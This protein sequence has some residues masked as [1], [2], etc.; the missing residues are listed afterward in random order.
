MISDSS[1][2]TPVFIEVKPDWQK[3]VQVV[4][5]FR[6]TIAETR[7]EGRQR[8]RWRGSPRYSITYLSTALTIAEH[9]LRRAE[10]LGELK[11]PLVCPIWPDA[12]ALDSMLSTHVADLGE[13]LAKKRF[14]VGSYA[15][16]EQAGN[17]STF[18]KIASISGTTITFEAA[19]V[20]VFTSGA[21]VYPCVVGFRPKNSAAFVSNKI[22]QS[23]EAVSVEEL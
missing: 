14:K 17:V 18:R 20:P 11:A 9:G 13:S 7:N 21:T 12:F 8:A 2:A 16:F 15:Y 23:D 4:T 19:S 5:A 6:T 22:D 3:P 10:L 1:T